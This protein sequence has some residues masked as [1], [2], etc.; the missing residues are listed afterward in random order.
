MGE[1][2]RKPAMCLSITLKNRVAKAA[3]TQTSNGGHVG[4]RPIAVRKGN[5]MVTPRIQREKAFHP[6]SSSSSKVKIP[7]SS[8]SD[9]DHQSSPVARSLVFDSE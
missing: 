7:L 4:S 9:D 6:A 3:S 1:Q 5:P 2:L 8:L